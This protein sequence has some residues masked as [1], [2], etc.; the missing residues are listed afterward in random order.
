MRTINVVVEDADYERL[1]KVKG[2]MG[3]REFI[4][5]LTTIKVKK[6]GEKVER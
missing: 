6:N 4:M 5:L 1:E 2:E 3:W